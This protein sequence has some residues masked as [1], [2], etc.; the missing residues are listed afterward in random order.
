MC[1]TWEKYGG[2]THRWS[3]RREHCTLS[4]NSNK[5]CVVLLIFSCWL[6]PG[7]TSCLSSS[8]ALRRDSASQYTDCSSCC[9]RFLERSVYDSL[10]PVQSLIRILRAV[11]S[12]LRFLAT[13][14]SKTGIQA[15]STHVDR[16]QN[17]QQRYDHWTHRPRYHQLRTTPTRFALSLVAFKI[18]RFTESGWE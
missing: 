6:P 13:P 16:R 2:R 7:W 4:S 17:R 5:S 3:S 18:S 9:L 8:E 14:P 10:E 1:F 12:T 15:N 11:L